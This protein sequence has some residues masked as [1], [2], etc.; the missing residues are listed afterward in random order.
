MVRRAVNGLQGV[1]NIWLID[2]QL[3]KVLAYSSRVLTEVRGD[4]IATTG[5]PCLELNRDEIFQDLV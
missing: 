4:R 1:A 3:R 5:D 2:P